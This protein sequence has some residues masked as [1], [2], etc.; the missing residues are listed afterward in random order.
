MIAVSCPV[1]GSG[2][3]AHRRPASGSAA[4]SFASSISANG[5]PAAW[6][7]TCS[8]G[9]PRGGCGCASRSRP[10][11]GRVSG[12][13][14]RSAR[15]RW[16]PAGGTF[17]GRRAS[18]A[19]CSDSRRRAAKASASSRGTVQPLCVVN[20]QQQRLLL[21]QPGEQ[22]KHGDPGQQ[23]V[24]RRRVVGRPNAPRTPRLFGRQTAKQSSTRRSRLVQ[25]GERQDLLRLP[26]GRRRTRL[27]AALAFRAVFGGRRSCPCRIAQEPP[28][29]AFGVRRGRQL[30]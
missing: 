7:R 3:A 5:L 12:G 16:K 18:S 21:R 26:A 23:R 25:P 6:A 20:G 22:G 9:R 29:P 11:S 27:P 14:S 17:R 4:I 28:T 10:A 1:S 19:S 30:P 24:G 13:S 8:R 2:S 15:S